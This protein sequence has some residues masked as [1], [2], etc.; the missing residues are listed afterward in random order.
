MHLLAIQYRLNQVTRGEIDR[1]MIFCPPRHG[2]SELTTVR[3]PV[4]RLV[5]NPAFRVILGAY[6][7][8][9]AEKMSRKARAIAKELLPLSRERKAAQEWETEQGG[10]LRATGVGSAPTGQGGDLLLIDD[11]VKQRQEAESKAY[12]DRVYDWYKDDLLTRLEPGGAV[13]LIMTR[14]NEDDLAGR[15]LASEEAEEWKVLSLPALAEANDPLRRAIGAALCPDRFDE[16]ALLRR[17]K[18]LGSYSFASLYQQRPAPAEGGLFK[19]H[20]FEIVDAVPAIAKRVRFWDFAATADGGDFTMG[21]KAAFAGGILYIEDVEYGQWSPGETDRVVDATAKRDGKA[22]EIV[23]EEEPGSA[24]KKATAAL[25]RLLVGYRVRGER[26]TG[27][28]EVRAM[29]VAAQAEAGNVKMVRG[30]W[31][32]FVLDQLSNFPNAKND[33]AVDTLSG[34]FGALVGKRELR[35]L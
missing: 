15:I 28:K 35:V 26:P 4:Y 9:F 18:Q 25:I 21:M 7:Q 24:G 12:R 31:N 13:I 29:P 17:R 8:T 16:K 32:A 11:P 20:W 27:S 6:N 14:W 23:A 5:Q 1:L 10:G 33:E 2:K 34:V 22:V 19:R 30:K 3:Y